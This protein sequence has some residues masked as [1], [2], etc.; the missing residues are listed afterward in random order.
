MFIYGKWVGMT[1]EYSRMYLE[2]VV[3]LETISKAPFWA[4]ELIFQF[5]ENLNFHSSSKLKFWVSISKIYLVEHVHM[6]RTDHLGF[7]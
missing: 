7:E 1:R 4:R 3:D 2:I 6:D 5:R